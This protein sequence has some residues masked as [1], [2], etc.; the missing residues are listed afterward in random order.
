MIE[1]ILNKIVIGLLYILVALFTV[2][3]ILIYPLSF[4]V[5]KLLVVGGEDG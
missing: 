3:Y 1:R 5:E 2:C 4:I